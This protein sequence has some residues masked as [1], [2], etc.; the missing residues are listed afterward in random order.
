MIYTYLGHACFQ[1]ELH[2]KT[3]LFDPFIR[4]NPK[5][6][7]IDFSSLKPDYI[8]VSHGH[9]DHVADLVE[10]AKQSDATVISN[11]E[12]ASWCEKQGIA[13]TIGMNTGGKVTTDFGSVKLTAAVHSS[14]LPDGSYAGNPNGFLIQGD[15][16]AIY[17][18]G[19][20]SLTMDMQLVPIWAHHLDAAILPIGDHFTM[21]ID[22]AVIAA[23]WL[24]TKLVLPVHY[25]TFP[26]IMINHDYAHKQFALSGIDLKFSDI[27]ETIEI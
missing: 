6:A 5:A 15:H 18:S 23:S 14:I 25:D 3:L 16:K 22:D 7:A 19:D 17:Y 13:K 21:G 1:L 26:P 27:G 12:I 2:G 8:L 9:Y 24:K 20:S 4:P 10:L 11:F